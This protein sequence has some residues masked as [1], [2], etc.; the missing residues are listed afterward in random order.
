MGVPDASPALPSQCVGWISDGHLQTKPLSGL[1][2][3]G[4][5]A[6]DLNCK[7]LKIN[8]VANRLAKRDVDVANGS[9]RQGDWQTH[10]FDCDNPR[11]EW[12]SRSGRNVHVLRLQTGH[13]WCHLNYRFRECPTIHRNE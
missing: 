8:R 7:R 13:N 4:R 9:T 5:V 1:N 11:S 12:T 10:P 2:R 3:H 6:C